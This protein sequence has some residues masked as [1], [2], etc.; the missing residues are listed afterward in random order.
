VVLEWEQNAPF[1]HLSLD[2]ALMAH[3]NFQCKGNQA[4]VDFHRERVRQVLG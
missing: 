4:L 3:I 2:E 1:P